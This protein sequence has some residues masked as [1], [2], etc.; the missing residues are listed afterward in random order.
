MHHTDSDAGQTVVWPAPIYKT[1]DDT[2]PRP[3]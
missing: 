1:N 3:I 2:Y